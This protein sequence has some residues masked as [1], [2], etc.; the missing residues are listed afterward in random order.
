MCRPKCISF[1]LEVLF[2]FRG[3]WIAEWCHTWLLILVCCAVP[4]DHEFE[5]QWWQTLFW[6]QAQHLCF[7]HDSIWFIWFEINICLSNLSCELSN[8]KLKINKYIFK[9]SIIVFFLLQVQLQQNS[10]LILLD[11]HQA[12]H[13][14]CLEC[15]LCTQFCN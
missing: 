8:K 1:T 2:S 14:W 11:R 13:A 5:P 10:N 9:K 15:N 12:E 3:A 7:L 6:T 4:M